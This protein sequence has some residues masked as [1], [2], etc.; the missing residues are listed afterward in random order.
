VLEIHASFGSGTKNVLT[1]DNQ[2][3]ETDLGPDPGTGTGFSGTW[4]RQWVDRHHRPARRVGDMQHHTLVVAVS[5]LRPRLG[6]KTPERVRAW[7]RFF[8][9]IR[10]GNS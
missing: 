10:A 3:A 7:R 8:V 4:T 2:V 9:R 6:T 1:C 5:Q